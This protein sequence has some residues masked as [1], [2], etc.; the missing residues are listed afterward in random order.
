MSHRTYSHVAPHC[1]KRGSQISNWRH[2]PDPP[3]PQAESPPTDN[4]DELRRYS[5]TTIYSSDYELDF[6][7]ILN[8]NASVEERRKKSR[9]KVVYRPHHRVLPLAECLS[10]RVLRRRVME[11]PRPFP[12]SPIDQGQHKVS[13]VSRLPK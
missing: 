6:N 3:N 5:T 11:P 12:A 13:H 8:F 2:F 1:G 4:D 7:G 10:S 9:K